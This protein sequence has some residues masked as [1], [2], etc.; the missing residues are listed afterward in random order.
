MAIGAG[1]KKL[2]N[3]K[4]TSSAVQHYPLLSGKRPLPNQRDSAIIVR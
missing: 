2:C 4:A 1:D 3:S